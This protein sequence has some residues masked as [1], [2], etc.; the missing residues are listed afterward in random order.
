MQAGA[1][2]FESLFHVQPGF[3]SRAALEECEG[4]GRMNAIDDAIRNLTD[5][6]PGLGKIADAELKALQSR[7]NTMQERIANLERLLNKCH[8]WF[9]AYP[10][11][12]RLFEE[13]SARR[14]F[15]E[16]DNLPASSESPGRADGSIW[17]AS[18]RATTT[19]GSRM[20]AMQRVIDY[21]RNSKDPA[22][23]RAGDKALEYW[24]EMISK[25][26][27]QYKE[28]VELRSTLDGL[29]KSVKRLLLGR[30]EK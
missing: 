8:E 28:L 22:A 27:E 1:R 6:E 9:A 15:T 23:Q 3:A 29:R 17:I 16:L 19:N 26:D 10:F 13:N 4:E 25:Q 21:V 2:T 24:N 18:A 14:L 30:E 11:G 20:I 5:Y 7:V 12:N